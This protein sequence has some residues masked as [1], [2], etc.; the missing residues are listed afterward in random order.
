MKLV[1]SLVIY[2]GTKNKISPSSCTWSLLELHHGA[3]TWGTF[4]L[5]DTKEDWGMIVRITKVDN[6]YFGA[7]KPA[8]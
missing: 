4:F 8:L 2:I 3:H 7:L 5:A 6:L 1:R